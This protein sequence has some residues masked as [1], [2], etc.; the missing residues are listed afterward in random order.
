MSVMEQQ[1]KLIKCHDCQN[2]IPERFI[3]IGDDG[4]Y[5]CGNCVSKHALS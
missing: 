1:E 5:R 3:V 2:D 4:V